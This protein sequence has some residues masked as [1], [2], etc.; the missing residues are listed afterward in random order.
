LCPREQAITLM[1]DPPPRTL[2][3]FIGM[4]R[5]FRCGFD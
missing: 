5:P 4:E 2:P 1:L 3:I